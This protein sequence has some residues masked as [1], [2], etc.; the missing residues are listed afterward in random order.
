MRLAAF[1]RTDDPEGTRRVGLVV[2]DGSGWWLHP[3]EAGADRVE[4]LAADPAAREEAADDAARGDGLRPDDVV[5]LP[6]VQPVAMRDFLTFEAHVDGMERGLELSPP[7]EESLFEIDAA[8]IAEMGIREMPGSLGEA[9]D[10]LERDAVVR[11]ALGEHVYGHFIEAKRAEW[12]DFRLH[13][14]QWELDRYL[15]AF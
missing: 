10:E 13:V 3:F 8:R 1:R 4:L 5:L 15:E 6:P 12:N 14:S 2:G 7:V 9:I 11:E